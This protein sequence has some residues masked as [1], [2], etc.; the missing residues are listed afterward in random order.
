MAWPMGFHWV[1]FSRLFLWSYGTLLIIWTWGPIILAAHVL[2]GDVFCW[3]DSTTWKSIPIFLCNYSHFFD[4]FC[5]NQIKQIASNHPQ[6]T[7]FRSWLPP[8]LA[9]NPRTEKNAGFPRRWFGKVE[10][11]RHPKR[12]WFFF[13]EPNWME[14]TWHAE[15]QLM[16]EDIS[17]IGNGI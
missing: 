16:N 17:P 5:S 8:P 14:E 11:K 9:I 10:Q 2:V 6:N 1:L 4:I 3:F 15:T 13:V 12:R 7:N